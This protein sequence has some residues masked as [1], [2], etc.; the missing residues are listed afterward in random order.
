MDEFLKHKGLPEIGKR[1]LM[2]IISKNDESSSKINDGNS[3]PHLNLRRSLTILSPY[4]EALK[5]SIKTRL[6]NNRV[7]VPWYRAYKFDSPQDV[8]SDYQPFD[9]IQRQDE[10]IALQHFY[11]ERYLLFQDYKDPQVKQQRL[12]VLRMYN[13]KKEKETAA[14]AITIVSETDS[15][16]GPTAHDKQKMKPIIE[17]F[18]KMHVNRKRECLARSKQKPNSKWHLLL[19]ESVREKLRELVQKNKQHLARTKFMRTVRI[20]LNVKK[21]LASIT[22]MIT[23]D[24]ETMFRRDKEYTEAAEASRQLLSRKKDGVKERNI[25]TANKYKCNNEIN[26]P[27]SVKFSLTKPWFRRSEDEVDEIVQ[28][29]QT[30]KSFVEYPITYQRLIG[31][32]AW[33]MELPKYKVVIREGQQAFSFYF[34]VTGKLSMTRLV[35]DPYHTNYS[36]FQ[37]LTALK[38]QD[39]FGE[40]CIAR[41]YSVRTYSVV[42]EEPTLLLSVNIHEVHKMELEIKDHEEAPEHIKFLSTLRFLELFPKTKLKDEADE[43]IML[44]YFRP[45]TVVTPDAANSEF[46]YVVS[47]GTCQVLVEIPPSSKMVANY[48]NYQKAK[49]EMKA[50]SVRKKVSAYQLIEELQSRQSEAVQDKTLTTSKLDF[51]SLRPLMLTAVHQKTLDLN[52][53]KSEKRMEK[54][55]EQMEAEVQRLNN[56]TTYLIGAIKKKSKKLPDFIDEWSERFKEHGITMPNEFLKPPVKYSPSIIIEDTDDRTNLFEIDD[57]I[58]I[59][60]KSSEKIEIDHLKTECMASRKQSTGPPT[61]RSKSS[62]GESII[63]KKIKSVSSAF[64]EEVLLPVTKSSEDSRTTKKFEPYN[65]NVREERSNSRSNSRRNSRRE[66]R[67]HKPKKNRRE[68]KLARKKSSEEEDLSDE[69]SPQKESEQDLEDTQKDAEDE[70]MAKGGHS[71]KKHRAK[72]RHSLK[73][74]NPLENSASRSKSKVK[75]EVQKSGSPLEQS[76]SPVTLKKEP[77]KIK[78]SDKSATQKSATKKSKEQVSN[79][80]TRVKERQ[81]PQQIRSQM[82]LSKSKENTMPEINEISN[83]SLHGQVSNKSMLP[84]ARLSRNNSNISASIFLNEPNKQS[85]KN[86]LTF[87]KI[88]SS[89]TVD[90]TST[91]SYG[92]VSSTSGT[93]DS[94]RRKTFF[95][96]VNKPAEYSKWKLR[97][98]L[99]RGDHLGTEW[100]DYNDRPFEPVTEICSLVSRGSV[101]IMIRKT[102]LLKYLR[103]NW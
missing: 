75:Q 70:K 63:L 9:E 49:F 36:E 8:V 39:T 91:T 21:F 97:S 15:I 12:A 103:K 24:T 11:G 27:L 53:Q 83:N 88:S 56:K 13:K 60:Q 30:L 5:R 62:I 48:V 16:F 99:L 77:R 90:D 89:S 61:P 65:Q 46:V 79:S 47:W 96:P 76:H 81:S 17:F 50:R 93:L 10:D 94:S 32:A 51:E 35:G 6:L 98:T 28:C 58:K 87:S 59:N 71:K 22:T 14:Q 67:S 86:S 68:Q 69:K 85:K 33:L 26:V 100:L 101:V 102:F 43:N 84:N 66:S 7:Y 3:R 34:V 4:E 44:F 29:F 40:E 23:G 95:V 80:D 1:G 18:N 31:R 57:L 72:R 38:A 45:N 64:S 74:S 41:P 82:L 42:V 20:V 55:K 37:R 2:E 19:K 73:K 52:I 78:K 54:F 92:Y 25:F